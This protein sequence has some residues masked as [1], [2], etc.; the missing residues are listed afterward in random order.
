MLGGYPPQQIHKSTQ[1]GPNITISQLEILFVSLHY[2]LCHV[3]QFGLYFSTPMNRRPFISMDKQNGTNLILCYYH[4][5]VSI[6]TK[7]R[8]SDS[9]Y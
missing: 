2:L 9:S 4:C 1:N 6:P 7:P 5:S 8:F 3:F